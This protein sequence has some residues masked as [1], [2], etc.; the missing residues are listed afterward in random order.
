MFFMLGNTATGGRFP[1][2]SE[3]LL[4]ASRLWSSSVGSL[5]VA[6]IEL[7]LDC[8]SLFDRSIRTL[9]HLVVIERKQ[10]FVKKFHKFF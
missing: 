8:R 4:S 7:T 3:S 1:K 9:G 10:T 2:N 6:P 5:W